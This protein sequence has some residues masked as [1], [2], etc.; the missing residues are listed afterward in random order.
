[1]LRGQKAIPN[2]YNLPQQTRDQYGAKFCNWF[3]DE[4]SKVTDQLKQYI[5]E[6]QENEE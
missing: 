5:K 4:W 1:M 6:E 3:Y 2:P